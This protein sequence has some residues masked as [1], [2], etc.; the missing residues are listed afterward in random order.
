VVNVAII[1]GQSSRAELPQA[2]LRARRRWIRRR[3]RAGFGETSGSRRVSGWSRHRH[4]DGMDAGSQHLLCRH[5]ARFQLG[6][7]CHLLSEEYV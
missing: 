4:T 1:I 2:S 3:G 5:R 6:P 7:P